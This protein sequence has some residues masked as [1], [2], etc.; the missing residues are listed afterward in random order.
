MQSE[1]EK[2]HKAFVKDW[3][4]AIQSAHQRMM[5]GDENAFYFYFLPNGE[6]FASFSEA[7]TVPAGF[8][9]VTGE[10]ISSFKTLEQLYV[11]ASRLVGSVPYYKV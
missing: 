4:T 3:Q 6:R 11:W 10:R 8:Q 1:Y 2:R 9:L 7:E 5:R